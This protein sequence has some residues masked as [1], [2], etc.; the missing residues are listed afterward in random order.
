TWLIPVILISADTG[1]EQPRLREET[2]EAFLTLLHN[3]VFTPPSGGEPI[4]RRL[5]M[6][7]SERLNLQRLRKTVD[8]LLKL[9]A[10]APIRHR[11][12]VL[13]LAAWA[14]WMG[15]MGTPASVLY[16]E[17]R[18]LDPTHPTVRTLETL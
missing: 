12:G 13:T 3:P 6:S 9:S 5:L 7:S 17:A 2:A 10:H 15:A 18:S 14:W 1:S 8:V 16:E 11:T 4:A